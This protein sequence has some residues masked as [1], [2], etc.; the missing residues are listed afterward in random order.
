MRGRIR[1]GEAA[2]LRPPPR[3][4]RW[5]GTELR[6]NWTTDGGTEDL[7]LRRPSPGRGARGHHGRFLTQQRQLS[8]LRAEG[9]GHRPGRRHRDHYRQ[10][11]LP[12]QPVHP[13]LAQHPCQA[14]DLGT[15]TTSGPNLTPP[16]C[17]PPLRNAAPAAARRTGAAPCLGPAGPASPPRASLYRGQIHRPALGLSMAFKHVS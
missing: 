17:L 4:G 14:L 12:Q 9:R 5:T 6:A 7:D 11:L 2:H 16:L 15:A 1:F 3:T 10:P 13:H 8:A